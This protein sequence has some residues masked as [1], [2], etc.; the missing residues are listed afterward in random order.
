MREL[1]VLTCL[2]PEDP[3]VVNAALAR[4]FR[5]GPPELSNRVVRY[6]DTFDWRL[7][8]MN[9]VLLAGTDHHQGTVLAH[10]DL[11]GRFLMECTWHGLLEFAADLK[12]TALHRRLVPVLENRRLLCRAECRQVRIRRAVV[13][14]QGKIRCRL[15]EIYSA[16]VSDASGSGA[17]EAIRLLKVIELRGYPETFN[18]V[19]EL[20]REGLKLPVMGLSEARLVL[21]AA[22]ARPGEDPSRRQ[23]RPSR[24]M[25]TGAAVRGI[26]TWLWQTARVNEEG[27]LRD[28][29][30]EFL[31][32]YRVAVRRTRA[33]VGQLKSCFPAEEL[34]PFR[35]ELRWLS[36]L[37]GTPRDLDVH[38]EQLRELCRSLS[39]ADQQ[40]IRPLLDWL[41][42]KRNEA[43][44]TLR[45]GLRSDRYQKLC[46]HWPA[47]VETFA[48]T[49]ISQLPVEEV[50]SRR[51][52]RLCR[53]AVKRGR[54]IHLGQD[55]QRLHLLRILCKKLRYLLEFFRG[56]YAPDPI[57]SMIRKLKELQD[58]LGRL[59]DFR[60]QMAT[61]NEFL[62]SSD[63]PE[64]P[65]SAVGAAVGRL[66][67]ELE[68]EHHQESRKFL[69]RFSLFTDEL[70]PKHLRA[71]LGGRRSE[72]DG[73]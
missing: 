65:G 67:W 6:L 44:Q 59:N 41:E 46:V 32:D 31:H 4:Q 20:I 66:L 23:F 29:D 39:P 10:F 58:C 63:E 60:V 53:R 62:R 13:G 35:E 18:Q 73:T 16:P 7:W 14:G 3:A 26:L 12:G 50:A 34:A 11:Q 71:A 27:I 51:I 69:D 8:K 38:C 48:E 17:R 54:R 24:G 70:R 61:L 64:G 43:H 47:F 55:D 45:A 22:G 15:E 56:L 33:L 30:P 42:S 19:E 37:T 21:E 49:E 1:R 9:W 72:G 25:A 5:L 36:Q 52:T 40:V 28:L 57:R 68:Q 2:L